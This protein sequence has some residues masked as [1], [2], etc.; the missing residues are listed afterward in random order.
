MSRVDVCSFIFSCSRFRC[1]IAVTPWSICNR[2]L[3]LGLSSLLK[4]T[5][6][7]LGAG[8]S[9]LHCLMVNPPLGLTTASDRQNWSACAVRGYGIGQ[10]AADV[11][12]TQYLLQYCRII[13]HV[14][15]GP[16]KW[17]LSYIYYANYSLKSCIKSNTNNRQPTTDNY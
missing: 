12:V 9:C 1:M 7:K 8:G 13:K 16:K 15:G 5:M 6:T 3:L 10:L 14:Q 11:R 2:I 17:Y 4:R